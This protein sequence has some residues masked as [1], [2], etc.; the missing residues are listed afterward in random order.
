MCSQEYK[1]TVQGD[2]EEGSLSSTLPGT[3]MQSLQSLKVFGTKTVCSSVC[4]D[5]IDCSRP[6]CERKPEQYILRQEERG[7][8]QWPDSFLT[9]HSQLARLHGESLAQASGIS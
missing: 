6:I 3:V 5:N 7:T 8:F 2:Q 9:I 1:M 4:L